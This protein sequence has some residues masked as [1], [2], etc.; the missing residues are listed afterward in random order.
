MNKLI[1]IVKIIIAFIMSLTFRSLET[2][3]DQPGCGFYCWCG[4]YIHCNCV[5]CTIDGQELT[6]CG[7]SLKCNQV[8]IY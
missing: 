2:N 1:Y 5:P 3:A 4:T 7:Y 8:C 6:C